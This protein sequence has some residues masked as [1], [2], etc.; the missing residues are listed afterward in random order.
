MS[1]A[2]TNDRHPIL[3]E[4]RL[5]QV[6]AAS[7][8]GTGKY[9]YDLFTIG[10]GSGGVRAT[11]FSSSNYGDCCHRPP[12]REQQALLPLP[13]ELFHSWYRKEFCIG[14]F[15]QQITLSVTH[16]RYIP[17]ESRTSLC[18]ARFSST[19]QA[20]QYLTVSETLQSAGAKTAI[21]EL[22]FARIASDE[23]GGAGGT[24]VLRGCVPK[25]LMV[26]GGEFAEA[27]RDSKA[28]G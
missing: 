2:I 24:C 26:Y 19:P 25:K 13:A 14:R 18:L 11:R 27:F 1:R 23:F 8:N 12:S 7:S 4:E 28:Y 15:P 5:L 16:G 10:A 17:F 9:D 3:L 21:C 22:P 6:R 20:L